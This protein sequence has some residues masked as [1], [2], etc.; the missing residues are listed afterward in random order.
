MQRIWKGSLDTNNAGI[1]SKTFLVAFE[2][3]SQIHGQAIPGANSDEPDQG[4]SSRLPA[5]Q[6]RNEVTG[7]GLTR[8]HPLQPLQ[9]TT[10][11]GS[12]S[13]ANL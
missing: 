1:K 3:D 11:Y 10:S 12:N 6:H 2:T 7:D 4:S 5:P 8:A 9:A 13:E